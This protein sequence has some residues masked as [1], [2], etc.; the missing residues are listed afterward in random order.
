MKEKRILTLEETKERYFPI[1]QSAEDFKKEH[2][3]SL[4]DL[5]TRRRDDNT[6]V[7]IPDEYRNNNIRRIKHYIEIRSDW[8]KAQPEYQVFIESMKK[9]LAMLT[10]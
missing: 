3:L 6:Y 1:T 10:Q 4:A 2:L 7:N 8:E 5:E 9:S